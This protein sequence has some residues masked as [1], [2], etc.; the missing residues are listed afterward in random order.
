[1]R[2]RQI[3]DQ[4]RALGGVPDII[5]PVLGRVAALAKTGVE[6]AQ[7]FPEAILGDLALEHQLLDRARYLKVL[8]TTAELGSVRRL[9]ERLE[10][11]HTAT[12]EWLTIVLAE[13]ALGGPAA[14]RATPFQAITGGV[15]RLANLP[16]R[17]TA[18]QVNRYLAGAQRSA[19]ET[20]TKVEQVAGKATQVRSAVVDVL[21]ASRDAGLARAEQVAR[22]DG[23]TDLAKAVHEARRETGSLN[24]DELPV[25]NYD[26]L[27]G[28]QAIE[29]VKS[30]ED[31]KD[32]RTIVAYEESHKAR[33]SVVSAAQ[34]Q[35]ARVAKDAVGV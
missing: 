15:T 6:Q 20:R 35:L 31:S 16:S 2:S 24:N 33:S 11:A 30:I 13:E 1:M 14:L 29:A 5:G 8:A 10:A 12:V 17:W 28:Q 19:E 32:I 9:A 23:D 3:V 34:A 18:Q 22:R 26:G 27:T 7:P 21:T 25:K 4:L